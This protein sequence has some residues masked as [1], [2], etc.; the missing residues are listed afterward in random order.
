MF[1]QHMRSQESGFRNRMQSEY[2]ATTRTKS[3]SSIWGLLFLAWMLSDNGRK[4]DTDVRALHEQVASLRQSMTADELR[5]A[6]EISV[7]EGWN[8]PEDGDTGIGVSEGTMQFA[9]DTSQPAVMEES[10][11]PPAQA[12]AQ[13]VA[14][15][16]EL[17]GTDDPVE[18]MFTLAGYMAPFSFLLI[19]VTV[20]RKTFQG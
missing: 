1:Q 18:A 6:Q 3:S 20:M 16:H 10:P 17:L 7:Q 15:V 13:V 14:P 9:D 5:Y 12:M 19:M 2:A 11:A 4:S 8:L